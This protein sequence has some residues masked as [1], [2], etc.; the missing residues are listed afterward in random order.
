MRKRRQESPRRRGSINREFAIVTY[1]F[2]LLFLCMAGY[3]IY[4]VGYAGE[5]F[6]DSPYNPRL[7]QLSEHIIRGDILAADGTVL[8]T[9]EVDDAQ[10]ETRVY[11]KG[12][13]YAH[14]VGFSSNGMSGT[15]LDANFQLLRSHSFFI[16]KI[17]NELQERKN[18]GD[19]VVTSLD[20]ALTDALY[21]G[22]ANYEGAAVA[23]DPETGKILAMVSKPDFDPNTIAQNWSY[24][25]E[26]G[27]S[28]LLNRA[29][30]GQ[31][32]PGSTFKILTALEYLNEGGGMEDA[33]NCS[34][35]YTYGDTT[36]HCYHNTVHGA[37]NFEEAFAHSC[38]SVFAEVGL[39]L[40]KSGMARLAKR[41][42][43]NRTLPT[44]LKNVK[45]SSFSLK[46]ADSGLVMRTAIGQGNTLVTPIH[47]AMIASAI[48]NDGV[49]MEP[50]VI[51]HTQNDGGTLVRRYHPVRYG[52]LFDES[53]VGILREMMRYVVTN[54]TGSKLYT[55]SY[56]AY[57][58]TGTAEFSDN[59]SEAHSWFVGFA[60]QDEK[61][62][63]V[64]IVLER[65]G[66]GSEHAV[67]LARTMFDTYF[68]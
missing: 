2:L 17:I 15:E 42:L 51:D 3:F 25:T 64:A 36:I 13:E 61:K 23:L 62:I 18:Q 19:A 43:F 48:A 39:S 6:I 49:L 40:D 21:V 22:M 34:G 24:Y 44:E 66:S 50:S 67:P 12:N 35:S 32:P 68:R 45:K 54:G 4:F 28:V 10:N 11:P 63:A 41:L 8:A 53:E 7:S 46:D 58:K 38:N 30:Q 60:E 57:G 5:D 20:T 55:D 1:G 56:T 29:I 52:E 16:E 26:T 9:S 31:Y 47:M 59:K 65:A 37:Q 14:I 33:F 27:S